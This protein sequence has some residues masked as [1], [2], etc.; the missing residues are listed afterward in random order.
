M[1][2]GEL[3]KRSGLSQSRIRFYESI[4]LLRVDRKPNGYRTYPTEA[5]LVLDLI[6]SAQRAGFSLDE[7]RTLLPTDLEHWEHDALIGTLRAKVAD[8]EAL[9][10]RL[11]QSKAHLIAVIADIEAK[12]DHLSCA[13]NA[14][15]VL[16]RLTDH[17]ADHEEM[18]SDDVRLLDKTHRRQSVKQVRTANIPA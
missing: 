15:R 8:I 14:R 3:A 11:T 4:G 5:V 16:S 12:P 13:A 10:A 9:E 6:A 2:I 18:A 7:I 1:N 17:D